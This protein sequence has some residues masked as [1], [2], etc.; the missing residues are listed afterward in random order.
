MNYKGT[1]IEESLENKDVLKDV[2]ILSTEVEQVKEK[3]KTP[4]LEHWTLHTVEIP[5]EKVDEVV[6]KIAKDLESILG[7]VSELKNAPVLSADGDTENRALINI[8]REDINS[9]E[10][11]VY[12]D[13]LVKVFSKTRDNYL[14]VKPILAKNE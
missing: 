10:A 7:Y 2:V 4:W 1:I 9:H 6:E 3:H 8:L 5:E 14:L 12:T 13:D 11:G